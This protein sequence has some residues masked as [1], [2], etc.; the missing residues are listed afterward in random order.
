M[1]RWWNVIRRSFHRLKE[2]KARRTEIAGGSS[3]AK[4][5]Q[6]FLQGKEAEY[7]IN[8]LFVVH[9]YNTIDQNYRLRAALIMQREINK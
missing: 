7:S 4:E 1:M 9:T 3:F 6:K 5:Q 2:E 8:R